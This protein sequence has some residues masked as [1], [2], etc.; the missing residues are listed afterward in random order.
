MNPAQGPIELREYI[1]AIRRHWWIV[2]II[3]CVGLA[4]ALGYLR[5]APKTYAATT[6]VY[7]TP[8]A[9]DQTNQVANTRTPGKV[10]LDTE[11]QVVQSGEV[12]TIASQ[13]LH[14]SISPAALTENISV[15]VPANSQVLR[16]T[17]KEPSAIRA[18][19]CAQAFAT[20]YLKH[21]QDLASSLIDSQRQALQQQINQLQKSTANLT[22]QL[23]TLPQNSAEGLLT[24]S[25]LSSEQ[26]RLSSLNSQ[27]AALAGESTKNAGGYI[28]TKASPPSGPDSPVKLV[29]LPSGLVIGLLFGLIVSFRRYQKSD[30]IHGARDIHRLFGLPV[31]LELPSK[32]FLRGLSIAPTMSETGQAFAELARLVGSYL[33]D[34]NHV[35]IVSETTSGRAGSVTA[36]NLAA[37]LARTHSDVLLVSADVSSSITPQLL[38]LD[39][40]S[41]GLVDIA[42]GKAAPRDVAHKANDIPGLWVITA[43]ADPPS[44]YTLLRYDNAEALVG[45]LRNAA[46]YVVIELPAMENRIG[47]FALAKFADSAILATETSQTRRDDISAPLKRFRNV[48]TPVTGVV[49]LPDLAR[50]SIIPQTSTH[51]PN[52]PRKRTTPRGTHESTFHISTDHV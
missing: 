3:T 13:L 6:A 2:L 41:P 37:G 46:R 50:H 34:G 22:A 30:R 49:L 18:S 48:Q 33:P 42:S 51:Q 19:K 25:Q 5:V 27:E 1:D 7:V 35:V 45:R 38:E 16:I 23:K 47:A 15:S 12:A 44:R 29:F 24:R 4:A 9:A 8:T 40:Y 14:S 26:T 28:I 39:E 36:A 21:R 32:A 31:I 43:G 17:C 11:A 52:T 10:N 20:A